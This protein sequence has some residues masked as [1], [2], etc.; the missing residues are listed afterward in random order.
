MAIETWFKHILAQGLH[1]ITQSN[2]KK[3]DLKTT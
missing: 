3:F 2:I 1:F